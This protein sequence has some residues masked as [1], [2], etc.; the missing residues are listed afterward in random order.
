MTK[1]LKFIS[2]FGCVALLSLAP[3]AQ[4][5]CIDE[6]TDDPGEDVLEFVVDTGT[7]CV[8]PGDD[9]IIY[10]HQ[11]D[12]QGLVRGFQ[13][14]MEF[15]AS[16]VQLES[17]VTTSDPYGIV[18]LKRWDN[19][20]GTADLIMGINDAM[21]QLPTQDDALL[22]TLTFSTFPGVECTPWVGLC[23][24]EHNPP[25][26]FSDPT[27]LPIYP[28]LKFSAPVCID[29]T[30]PVITCPADYTGQCYTD[31]P[32]DFAG[33]SVTD[34]CD[35]FPVEVTWR[36]DTDNGGTGCPGDPRI[37][38]RTYRAT[39]C[40]GNYA[41]CSQL[42]TFVDDTNPEITCP[43][44][45]PYQC[46]TEV[47]AADIT[48]PVVSD[49]CDTNPVVTHEGDTDN[50]G[51]GCA[52]DPRIIT[53]TYRVTDFCGNFAECQQVFTVID[54]TNPT[55]TCP[56][57]APYQCVTEVPAADITLPVV[58]DNCDTDPIV[59]HV[60]DTDNGGAGC[61]SDPLII[62]RTYRVTD[63]CG[64]F[65]ECTQT[66]TVIDDTNPTIT[67]PADANYQCVTEVP[68]ANI[69]LPVVSDNCD[70]DP[71]VTHVG[72]TDNGGAG[73]AADP[74]II[75]RVYRVTDFCGNFAEC[76]QTFTVIDDT[77]PTITCPA[78]AAY[79]CVTEMPAADITLPVVSDNCDTD[80]AVTHEGDTDNGGAGC[81]SDPL[82]ITRT[83]RVT[84][85]CGNF[86]ECQQVFTVIDDTNPT[87]TCPADAPYQCVTEVPAADITLP[88]VSD[89]C[90][91]D[92]A[93]THEGDTDN[94]GA[95]CASDPLIITRTYRATDFCGNFAEC[96]QVFTVIDDT[97]PSITCPPDGEYQCFDEV[98]AADVTLPVVSDNCDDDPTVTWQGDTD[99]GGSGC[100]G[101]PLIIQR[102]Y[103]VTD[104]CGNFKEC[105]Q[106]FIVI[107][108]TRPMI[109]CPPD[110][111]YQ[112]ADEVPAADTSL[113]TASDN[114]DDD[115]DVTWQGDTDNG[116]AGCVS[117]PLVITRTYRAT[118]VCGNFKDCQQTFTVVDDTAPTGITCPP[119]AQYQCSDEVPTADP[120]LVTATDNCDDDLTYTHEGDTDNGG[121]GCVGD[122]LV[123]T[124]TYRATD[125]CGNYADCQQ[126]FTVVDD[127]APTGITCPPDADYQCAADIPAADPTLVTAVDN[128][129][130]DLTY[131]WEGDTDNGGAGCQT[132][133]LIIT[134]TYRAWDDCENYAECTQTFTVI[135]TIAPVFDDGCDPPLI[136]VFP[137]AGECMAY[138]DL[139]VPGVTDNCDTAVDIEAFRSDG[140]DLTD[141]YEVGETNVWWVATDDCGNAAIC[142]QVIEVEDSNILQV[143]V[144][145]KGAFQTVSR[146]VNFELWNCPDHV[147]SVDDEVVFIPIF[148][149]PPFASGAAQLYVPCEVAYTCMTAQDRLHTLRSTADS[150][151]DFTTEI[152]TNS[153]GYD[154]TRYVA[155]FT[156]ARG[157]DLIP[158]N[159]DACQNP[160][161]W[162][163][164]VLDFGVFSWQWAK[165]YRNGLPVG[166]PP[167]N[168]HTPCPACDYFPHADIN[169]SGCVTAA[170]LSF[171]VVNILKEYQPN[172]CGAPGGPAPGQQPTMRI[173]LKELRDRGW[174][175]LGAGDLTNDG[176]LDEDD[177]TAFL[178]GARPKLQ[179]TP[180]SH[181]GP[182]EEIE[183]P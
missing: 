107:D 160:D 73:C 88:V 180:Q 154:R 4:A 165:C 122:P 124:R 43:A 95:G 10:L 155:Y 21:G 92:P 142:F 1:F 47:P 90:D 64:N 26:R 183:L 82:I 20:L 152:Y 102:K 23:F 147:W 161:D 42:L 54:D 89:N 125:D 50:G 174:A 75:E 8:Q 139:P 46:V 27:G 132:D 151:N 3:L 127:T 37:V 133:P 134:R 7:E 30:P 96:Q 38:T 136:K 153:Y 126:T 66:F 94:G 119:D 144:E 63:F 116:G 5:D 29:E 45:A 58:G 131:T 28:C 108:D 106:C 71:A 49:N 67:C 138:I 140:G 163:I 137:N 129:D 16:C 24:R 2:L 175:E 62:T 31:V 120:S 17:I 115:P 6:C 80:P 48:L 32:T 72:D 52:S 84:D 145:M 18:V 101:D 157:N 40:A 171:I 11:R 97:K 162:F 100:P 104:F 14:F 15:D 128:C 79:Q 86:A 56:A 170:D 77:D 158:G 55:I 110:A 70:T 76:T 51:A 159:L 150:P 81:A 13:A 99:N 118:D 121:A 156:I 113:V 173:S 19:T 143:Y 135:D 59:T 177:I 181:S 149:P 169:G 166:G 12:L 179:K 9:I 117:D 114:C 57:D 87:I 22:A 130:D 41:E 69:T 83:Y 68:A 53:R 78:D 85:F 36:G 178:N 167:V 164:D 25:S 103:R 111:N 141:P 109:T 65:A 33:G 112:C 148:G 93:V 123:I 176:W 61:A 44:D 98:P 91:T 182:A 168:G 60:G 39:D 35:A 172:C 105:S 146:C 34:N 74:L